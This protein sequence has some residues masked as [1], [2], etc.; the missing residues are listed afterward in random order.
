MIGI[1]YCR[2]RNYAIANVYLFVYFSVFVQNILCS[3]SIHLAVIS[4][5]PCVCTQNATVRSHHWREGNLA[6]NSKCLYCK[7]TCWSA[8]CL[9]G[10]RCE[11][12]GV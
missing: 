2:Q 9:A 5:F 6:G 8:E 10:I 1:G 3:N 11:W 7:K 4:N 12:C